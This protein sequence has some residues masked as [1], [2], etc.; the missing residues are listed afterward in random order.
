MEF[1]M[2][3]FAIILS[4]TPK[5]VDTVQIWPYADAT[6]GWRKDASFTFEKTANGWCPT[7]SDSD[8][9]RCIALTNG[10]WV[11]AQG[12][13]QLEINK[14]LSVSE[15][16]NYTFQPKDFERPLRFTIHQKNEERTIDI[17]EKGKTVRVFKAKMWSDKPKP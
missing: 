11:D 4:L 2:Y 15:K 10:N 1:M 12:K 13:V 9:D 3:M 6:N 8:R 14:N 16:T 7:L 5:D 17:K